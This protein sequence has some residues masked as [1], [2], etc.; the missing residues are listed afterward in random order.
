MEC[1]R[2]FISDMLFPAPD[3][4]YSVELTGNS[5][6]KRAFSSYFGVF[7]YIN[8]TSV[9][10]TF[11]SVLNNKDECYWEVKRCRTD[12]LFSEFRLSLMG[13]LIDYSLNKESKQ[14]SSLINAGDIINCGGN[15]GVYIGYDGTKGKHL[16]LTVNTASPDIFR[17]DAFDKEIQAK[18]FSIVSESG[19]EI[20]DNASYLIK[21]EPQYY[22]KWLLDW[23][24]YKVKCPESA[25]K[26]M[27]I[28]ISNDYKMYDNG[29]Y[30][31]R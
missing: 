12:M 13:K 18:E 15:Y 24:G 11:V 20:L 31:F 25:I 9:I 14:N 4:F 28:I 17:D 21:Q 26:N 19:I 22:L 10:D 29:K 30:W 2:G 8:T 5:Q 1:K 6:S 3:E 27:Q 7:K 23:D 16:C